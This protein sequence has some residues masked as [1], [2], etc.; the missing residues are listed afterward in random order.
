MQTGAI[1]VKPRW[2]GVRAANAAIQNRFRVG[3]IP[4]TRKA[5]IF[6][7]TDRTFTGLAAVNPG[8]VDAL[9]TYRLLDG[10]GFPIEVIEQPLPAHQHVA[11][12]AG[13]LFDLPARF[14]GLLE[15]ES[16]VDLV[17]ITLKLSVNA[18]GD[19]ILTTLPIADLVHPDNSSR[20]TF[21]QVGSGS[22]EGVGEFSTRLI[23]IEPTGAAA[24]EGQLRFWKGQGDPLR[25]DRIA[26]S[27][28]FGVEAGAAGEINFTDRPPPPEVSRGQ[29]TSKQVGP[30]GGLLLLQDDLE[31]LL[32][33]EIPAFALEEPVTVTMTALTEKPARSLGQN[34]FPG[35]VL[36]PEGLILQEPARLTVLLA[37]PLTHPD[38]AALQYVDPYGSHRPVPKPLAAGQVVE[39]DISHFS[40]FTIGESNLTELLAAAHSIYAQTD[41]VLKERLRRYYENEYGAQFPDELLQILVRLDDIKTLELY[42][43]SLEAL[44]Q[45]ASPAYIR[46]ISC[47]GGGPF[48]AVKTH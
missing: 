37:N 33:L 17:P 31:N 41:S 48:S 42:N 35:L 3:S 19:S 16:D 43:G 24:A 18:R 25:L 21:P 2:A 27:V 10:N 30:E 22:A 6:I 11:K 14:S 9:V 28:D 8:N 15:I 20:V 26:A 29:K 5:R 32:L 12:L 23:F 38:R 44:G 7:D 13:E 47:R 4:L 1:G 45:A 36:E 39:G 40:P 46:S 34:L